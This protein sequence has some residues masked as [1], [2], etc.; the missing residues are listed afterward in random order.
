MTSMLAMNAG[1]ITMAALGRWCFELSGDGF[2]LF[3][4]FG[5]SLFMAAMCCLKMPTGQRH[6]SAGSQLEST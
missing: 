3:N 2:W 4:L 1:V 5:T 6:H